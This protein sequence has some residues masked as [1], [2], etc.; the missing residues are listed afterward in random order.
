MRGLIFERWGMKE[1]GKVSFSPQTK[2]TYLFSGNFKPKTALLLP[3]LPTNI[4]NHIPMESISTSL[5]ES[6]QIV[7]HAVHHDLKGGLDGLQ[8]ATELL[9]DIL[10]P[11]Q[12]ESLGIDEPLSL[13]QMEVEKQQA[14]LSG[15][16]DWLSILRGG[17]SSKTPT[18][19]TELVE[20][21]KRDSFYPGKVAVE[22]LPVLSVSA[23][24]FTSLFDNLIK[25]GLHYNDKAEKWIR[26]YAEKSSLI[27][28]DN[29][30]GF[31][32]E[33]FD[34]LCSPFER[35]NNDKPGTGMG[36]AIVKS[37][38]DFHQFTL[39]A[40]SELG[41]GSRIIIDYPL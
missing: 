39:R 28:E 9:Q 17:E 4:L 41:S 1:I 37:I 10:P 38:C 15:L 29:G 30:N 12:L 16:K 27:V 40:E 3:S 7:A 36:M 8:F 31:P 22:T 26:I 19:L 35:L 34:K 20:R 25:N 18:D 24:Q 2:N 33:L 23:G 5:Q 13:I 14:I 11:E 6:L 21:L 32:I